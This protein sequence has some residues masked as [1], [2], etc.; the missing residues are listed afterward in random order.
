MKSK[1]KVGQFSI[2]GGDGVLYHGPFDDDDDSVYGGDDG[3]SN[4]V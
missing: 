4:H 3:V 1:Y 2:F